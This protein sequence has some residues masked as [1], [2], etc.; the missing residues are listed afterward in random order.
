M[1]EAASSVDTETEFRVREALSRMIEGRTSRRFR[2]PTGRVSRFFS[3]RL[4][5]RGRRRYRCSLARLGQIIATDGRPDMPQLPVVPMPVNVEIA[6][7]RFTA[8]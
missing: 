4:G 8:A 1:D 5:S 2:L 6:A 3:N 7:G